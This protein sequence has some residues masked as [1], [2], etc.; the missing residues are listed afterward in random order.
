MTELSYPADGMTATILLA[1]AR[2]I[3]EIS[4]S[5]SIN[6]SFTDRW[7]FRQ[8]GWMMYTSFSRTV[9]NTWS[10]LPSDGCRLPCVVFP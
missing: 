8:T 10:D 5:N 4:R 2:R 9:S 1:E 6:E 7:P 3:V